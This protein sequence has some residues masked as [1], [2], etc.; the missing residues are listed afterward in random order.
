MKN[1]P[2]IMI[3]ISA[4][5]VLGFVSQPSQA[6]RKKGHLSQYTKQNNQ[7]S[8]DPADIVDTLG[9][10]VG[11]TLTLAQA[12]VKK[13]GA[14]LPD[15]SPYDELAPNQQKLHKNGPN[16]LLFFLRF[17]VGHL[18]STKYTGPRY[19][20]G[21][22]VYV[23]PRN[24]TADY[25]D[26]DNLVVYY[27]E[28]STNQLPKNMAHEDF[29]AKAKTKFPDMIDSNS[30][31]D[32][33]SK[34]DHCHYAIA[35]LRRAPVFKRLSYV[36]AGSKKITM[37]MAA[38]STK[39]AWR[40]CGDALNVQVGS[41]KSRGAYLVRVFRYNYALAEEAFR[42]LSEVVGFTTEQEYDVRGEQ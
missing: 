41:H 32:L 14:T 21:F 27:V 31:P 8:K 1:K 42:N 18:P 15:P 17:D 7:Y 5:A 9:I 34:R 12:E 22:S 16:P 36:S 13:R 10:R 37:S 40:S 3:L 29:V 28:A 33:G 26:P 25:R 39:S 11:M 19:D 4:I 20:P 38:E 2:F 23:F 35:E 30:I 24:V 6:A